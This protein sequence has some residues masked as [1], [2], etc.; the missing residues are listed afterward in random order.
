M[1]EVIPALRAALI[2]GSSAVLQAPPGAGKTTHVPLALLDEPWLA[3]SKIL[4]LEP[5]RL[6][7][8]AVTHRMAQLLGERAGDTVGYRVRR[9]TR[10]G[11]RTRIEVV[12]EGILTRMLQSDP[13]LEGIGLLIF[14]EFHERSVHADTGLALALHS[15]SLVRSDLR[16][17]VMSATL[18]DARASQLFSVMHPL[19]LAR[20]ACTRSSWCTRRD[21]MPARC[22][23]RSRQRWS[24]R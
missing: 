16:I 1:D 5:R 7:A 18:D 4:M 10:V 6:A 3:G 23:L 12:T 9:D 17:L 20:A 24:M 21:P 19:S 13:T 8:R 11:S 15:R 2:A 22:L 14:D